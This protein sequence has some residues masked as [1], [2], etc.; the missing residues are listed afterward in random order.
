MEKKMSEN[1]LQEIITRE[2]GKRNIEKIEIPEQIKNA[3]DKI[4]KTLRNRREPK[5]WIVYSHSIHFYACIVEENKTALQFE[6]FDGHNERN[7]YSIVYSLD[8]HNPDDNKM[9]SSYYNYHR[10]AKNWYNYRENADF[11]NKIV[12]YRTEHSNK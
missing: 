7:H 2:Y 6:K 5:L 1:K 11:V 10:F 12:K 4:T 3:A 8:G 9:L